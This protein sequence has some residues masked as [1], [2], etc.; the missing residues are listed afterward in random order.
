MVHVMQNWKV[1]FVLRIVFVLIG[2]SPCFGQGMQETFPELWRRTLPA[3][4]PFLWPT[5]MV[6]ASRGDITKEEIL[7]FLQETYPESSVEKIYAMQS[8][9]FVPL[10]KDKF[11]LVAITDVTGRDFFN[12]IHMIRCEG[13]QCMMTQEGS[14]G[15]NDL[16]EQLV[17][18]DGDGVFEVVW[19]PTSSITTTSA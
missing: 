16:D 18:V 15:E 11:W 1:V 3:E 8:F 13:R 9:R 14:D 10:E 6:Q 7:R 19:R 5:D 2:G 12:D 17:D 4:P